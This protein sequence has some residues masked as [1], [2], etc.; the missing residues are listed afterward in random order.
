MLLHQ[1]LAL[2]GI[3]GLLH[4]LH[5]VIHRLHVRL[6]FAHVVLKLLFIWQRGCLRIGCVRNWCK[7]VKSGQKGK[8]V[9]FHDRIPEFGVGAASINYRRGESR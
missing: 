1:A 3:G 5:L 6:H 2:L 9:S 4:F 7:Q 8:C